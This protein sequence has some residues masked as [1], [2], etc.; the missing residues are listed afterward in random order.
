MIQKLQQLFH[1]DKWCGKITFII[2]LYGVYLILGYIIIPF[3][4]LFFQGFNFGGLFILIL[5]FIIIPAI[6]YVIPFKILKTLKLNNILLY[7]FH[8]VFVVATPFIF[9]WLLISGINP[10][11]F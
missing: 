11:F 3:I 8:T 7:F 2:F 4:V 10:N 9:L 5:L 1:T 6:S